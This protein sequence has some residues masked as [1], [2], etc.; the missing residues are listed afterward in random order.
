MERWTQFGLHFQISKAIIAVFLSHLV[1]IKLM[2]MC[3]GPSESDKTS[4]CLN[5]WPIHLRDRNLW[6]NKIE[7]VICDVWIPV[8]AYVILSVKCVAR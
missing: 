8:G 4:A 3:S 5:P 2:D 6:I 7:K 1:K